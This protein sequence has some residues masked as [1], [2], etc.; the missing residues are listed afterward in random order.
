MRYLHYDLET[1]RQRN[2]LHDT[3]QYFY[4]K[5]PKTKSKCMSNCCHERHV[6][7]SCSKQ[8]EFGL[9]FKLEFDTENR[10]LLYGCPSVEK[11]DTQSL[12]RYMLADVVLR[13]MG[14][15]F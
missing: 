5:L 12:D 11:Y 2:L 7:N 9:K 15:S 10:N 14:S 1:G 8:D 4:N 6:V 13:L 3:L